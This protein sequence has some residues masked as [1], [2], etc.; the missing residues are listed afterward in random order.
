VPS[1]PGGPAQLAN[2]H[3]HGGGTARG[4]SGRS[5]SPGR[6]SIFDVACYVGQT[7]CSMTGL[8]SWCLAEL[9]AICCG[10]ICFRHFAQG[11]AQSSCASKVSLPL[12]TLIKSC[13]CA[14]STRPQKIQ[15]EVMAL[16]P[17][18]IQ[19]GLLSTLAVHTRAVFTFPSGLGSAHLLGS[20]QFVAQLV[21]R[22]GRQRGDADRAS[23]T[24]ID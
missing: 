3:L 15:F 8:P 12:W 7:R 2:A 4:G 6:F 11:G 10:R 13:A 21:G 14:E 22:D 18:L 23:R 9:T 19:P 5:P 1:P 24:K 17:Q 16:S 20:T